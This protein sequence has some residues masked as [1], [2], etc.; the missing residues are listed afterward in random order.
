MA[1]ASLKSK[2]MNP[3][4]V[5][6]PVPIMLATTIAVAATSPILRR[7]WSATARRIM[8]WGPRTAPLVGSILRTHAYLS[9][10]RVSW[11]PDADR[12]RPGVLRLLRRR[13]RRRAVQQRH[14]GGDDAPG[15]AHRA[16]DA[17]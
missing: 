2:A 15:H 14:P 8:P 10:A 11:G 12:S 13:R 6:T 9:P 17:E 4:V 5:N 3:V 16:V 7:S 1:L